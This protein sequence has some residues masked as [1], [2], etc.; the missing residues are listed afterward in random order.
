[1]QSINLLRLKHPVPS[2]SIAINGSYS[3]EPE[4]LCTHAGYAEP[5]ASLPFSARVS[6]LSAGLEGLPA[7][8][9]PSTGMMSPVI[10]LASLLHKNRKLNSFF[11][12]SFAGFLVHSVFRYHL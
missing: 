5:F 7:V 3:L 10:H 6:A 2:I 9:P 1:M 8:V 11:D 12:C 4:R